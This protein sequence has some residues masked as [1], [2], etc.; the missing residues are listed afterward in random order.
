MKGKEIRSIRKRLGWTQV[1]LA[2]AVGV[3]PNTVARWE[4]DELS[5]SEPVS[6]LIRSIYTREKEKE[7]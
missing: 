7:K 2:A 3:A 1:N 6:R 5:I 4:R